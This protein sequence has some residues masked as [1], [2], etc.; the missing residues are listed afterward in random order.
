MLFY[1]ADG[2]GSVSVVSDV[3]GAPLN[4]YTYDPFGNPLTVSETVDNMFR[5]T[6]EPY[7]PSG[8]IFLRARYYDPST[9]RFLTPDT[10]TGQLNDPLSQNLYVYC[11]NNPVVYIDP[12][13]HIKVCK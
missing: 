4:R 13:G 6:G 11:G 10:I 9:G 3:Y 5:F 1:H 8:L 7:D 2:L 12:S